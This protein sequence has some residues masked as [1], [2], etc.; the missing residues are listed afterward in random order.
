MKALQFS[1][2]VPQFAVLKVLGSIRRRLYYEGPLATIRLVDI[3]EPALPSADWVKMR[4]F[5]CGF[6]GSDASAILLRESPTV[7]A[8]T[9]FPF[10]LGHEFCGEIIEV[11][12][13]VD[14]IRTGDVVTV[15]PNLSCSARGIEPECRSCQIGRPC[16]CE[17]YA[18][19]LLSPGMFAG[20]CRDIGGGFAPYVVAHK[21]QVFKLPEGMSPREGAMIEPL[22]AAIQAV[23]DNKPEQDDQVLIIGGG[24]IGNLLV[25]S[26]RALDIDCSITVA[27]P[28]QFH[29]ELASRVGADHL[30]TDGDVLRHTRDITGAR[31]YKPMLG[32]D[33]LMGGFSKIFDVV[34]STDT[35]KTS[36]RALRTG[37]VLSVV[38][39]GRDVKL[40]LTPLWLKL[41]TIMG[42][43]TYGYAD[44]NNERRHVFELAI[45]FA[46][47]KKVALEAMVTHI[48]RIEDYKEMIEVN[49][50]KPKHKAV[51]TAVSFT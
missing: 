5:M 4:T 44:V 51:K 9:S 40:D 22:A 24:V 1:V 20:A 43:Y 16:N 46:K 29:A 50:N 28:S 38:G 31:A 47:Q 33:I 3:P 18:E 27:E 37:G 19:G 39:I 34:G 11:G 13:E 15:A 48:F 49:L 23:L 12:S 26:I 7:T 45:D 30:I 17:N 36:M 25:Q 8:F 35:L 41:Q 32:S 2:S 6:C 14:G 42:V 10:T 21:S